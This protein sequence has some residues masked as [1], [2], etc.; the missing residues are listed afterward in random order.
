ML[1]NI[2][3]Y[4]LPVDYI[5]KEENYVRNLTVEEVNAQ[6][7]KYIDPMKMYYVVAGDAATQMKELKKLGF[8]DPILL[9]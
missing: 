3:Q 7:Q 6:V 4:G 5:S 9:N 1:N 2:A 8:G